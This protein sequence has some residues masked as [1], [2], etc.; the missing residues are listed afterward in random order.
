VDLLDSAAG[1]VEREGRRE[2]RTEDLYRVLSRQTGRMMS[3]L[4]RAARGT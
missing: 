3:A 2:M 1:L 4:E